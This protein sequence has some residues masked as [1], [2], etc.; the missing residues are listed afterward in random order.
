MVCKMTA[1]TYHFMNGEVSASSL[2]ERYGVKDEA[3]HINLVCFTAKQLRSLRINTYLP[4][5]SVSCT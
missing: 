5:L 2:T 1:D 3:V 4:S